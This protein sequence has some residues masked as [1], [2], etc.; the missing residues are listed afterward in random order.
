MESEVFLDQREVVPLTKALIKVLIKIPVGDRQSVLE[1]AGI[2]SAFLGNVRLE[3][4]YNIFAPALV[5][6]FKKY[7]INSRQLDYHPMVSFL[8]YI[9]DFAE[10]YNLSE[11]EINLFS[12]I[13]Q[14]G[15]ENFKALKACSGVGRIESPKGIGIGTGVLVAKNLLL[16]CYHV[17]NKSQVEQAWVRF[18]YKPG[19]FMLDEYL[20]KLD[21][22][23]ICYQ[24]R[25]DYALVRVRMDSQQL[26]VPPVNAFLDAAQE[27]RLI[28]HPQGKPMIISD[29]GKIMQ[30]GED[31][32]D[33]NI[34][35][36]E[37]S[38]GAP[39]FNHQWQLVAIHQGHPGIGRNMIQ[40][41]LGG[42]PIS[43]LW[44]Q[45]TPYL[46]EAEQGAN[47]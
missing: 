47:L 21:L 34:S 45:I 2:D 23:F 31:Y 30:V 3:T 38:S 24:N 7:R 19:S 44:N 28:H 22:N 18:N 8:S 42:I 43:A 15:Q 36:D 6:E 37:G 17:F 35:A 16:T 25:P 12:R 32:I 4:P 13:V 46:S 14:Q 29:I 40:G 5:A 20:F 26:I 27:I 39:I 1:S 9:R 41:T 33:H 10:I 11:E